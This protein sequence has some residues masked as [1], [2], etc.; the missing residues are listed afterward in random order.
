MMNTGEVTDPRVKGILL[1]G[2]AVAA[3]LPF[4]IAA[5]EDR[6][7]KQAKL[8]KRASR[9]RAVTPPKAG[10]MSTLGRMA[11]PAGMVC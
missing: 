5:L 3:G 6:A 2:G 7:R 1:G 10:I 8:A 11:G 4:G 9:G